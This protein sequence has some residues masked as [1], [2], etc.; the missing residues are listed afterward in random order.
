MIQIPTTR[1]ES[2]VPRSPDFIQ[3]GADAS[4]LGDILAAEPGYLAGEVADDP[5]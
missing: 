4:K 3:V 2:A 1:H 5:G